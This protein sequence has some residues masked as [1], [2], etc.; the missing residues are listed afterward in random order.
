MMNTHIDGEYLTF[1][2]VLINYNGTEPIIHIPEQI[3]GET[4]TEIGDGA[5]SELSHVQQI[6][7]PK[8]VRKIGNNAFSD[9]SNL[10]NISFLGS[11]E[12]FADNA[13]INCPAVISMVFD[14]LKISSNDYDRLKGNSIQS[15]TGTCVAMEF[16]TYIK[17]FRT[18]IVDG[19]Y[20]AYN[21]PYH[22]R[23]LFISHGE[24]EE[25]GRNFL[26]HKPECISFYSDDLS[27]T[28][29]AA[30]K[31]NMIHSIEE[32][33]FSIAEQE[34]DFR[35][36]NDMKSNISKTCIFTYDD[37]QTK[38]IEGGKSMSVVLR[39]GRIFWQSALKILYDKR[40]Y[41]LYR[42]YYLTHDSDVQYMR[43]D[44]AL[45]RNDGLV[46]D[47]SEAEKVYAKYKLP[48]I[49]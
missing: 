46:T 12:E 3:G 35:V 4:I 26:F 36:R 32:P 6:V 20:P 2:N 49:L 48:S 38:D 23:V 1:G 34:N 27:M 15:K 16:P 10:M 29:D 22:V 18:F 28:E 39:V 5:F 8:T 47:R 7:V 42:R 43:E 11:I 14:D 17:V 30:F 21:I 9:C 45:Y 24:N 44:I 37:S 41:Y 19:S 40:E 13:F 25:K 33:Y 31:D